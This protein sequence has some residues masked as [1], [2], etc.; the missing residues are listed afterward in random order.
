MS[1]ETEHAQSIVDTLS[2]KQKFTVR[3]IKKVDNLGEINIP[4]NPA[5]QPNNKNASYSISLIS[6]AATNHIENVKL[7]NNKFYY[8]NGT[9]EKSV[10]IPVGFYTINPDP[11]ID[12]F[13]KTIKRLIKKKGDNENSINIQI[14]DC[15]GLTTVTIINGYKVIW[16]NDTWYKEL[17]FELGTLNGDGDHTGI[18]IANLWPTQNIFMHCDVCRGNKMVKSD[19]RCEN[20][21]I[22]F[23]FNTNQEYGQ[24]VTFMLSPKNTQSELNLTTGQIDNIR[25]KFTDD[26]EKNINF[27]Q[28][29]IS[30]ALRISQD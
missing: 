28:T 21:D 26:N 16:K 12:D 30:L 1:I 17:G 15:T 18:N 10:T 3:V 25:I 27:C 8:H 2:K 7:T 13:V 24:P 11:N 14:S 20:S 6:F 9:I 19:G 29:E 22:L 4:I 5:F 23:Q